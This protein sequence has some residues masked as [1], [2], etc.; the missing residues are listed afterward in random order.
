MKKE[1]N[2]NKNRI[3]MS[4]NRRTM[5]VIL[6]TRSLLLTWLVLA[7]T[8]NATKQPPPPKPEVTKVSD[9]TAGLVAE[10]GNVIHK[11]TLAHPVN[12][13]LVSVLLPDK[14]SASWLDASLSAVTDEIDNLIT[15][16]TNVTSP[17][18][19]ARAGQLRWQNLVRSTSTPMWDG[20]L[21]PLA[22]FNN[23]RGQENWIVVDAK[24]LDGENGLSL[25]MIRI[26]SASND[27]LDPSQPGKNLLADTN[28]FVGLSYSSRAVGITKSGDHITSGPASQ[29]CARVVLAARGRLMLGETQ[30]QLDQANAWVSY[31]ANDK[32]AYKITFDVDAGGDASSKSRLVLS[33][34]P[35][36]AA[37]PALSI[38]YSSGMVSLSVT[39]GERDRSYQIESAPTPTGPWHPATVVTYTD[40]ITIPATATS[41]SF[42]AYVQ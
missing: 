19:Y 36:P 30:A 38:T 31:W 17:T 4:V 12:I 28:T 18:Q 8:V 11:N 40:S 10:Y 26:I 24:T 39:N 2:M 42:R 29:L 1:E 6:V 9:A 37:Q 27:D 3:T 33:T 32:G 23:E 41:E 14:A 34:D 25:D 16:R 35:T 15:S 21:N 13:R 20:T 7:S 22:P 5:S